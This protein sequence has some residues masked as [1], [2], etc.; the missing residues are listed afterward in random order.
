M[1][2]FSNSN[3]TFEYSQKKLNTHRESFSVSNG[4]VGWKKGEKYLFYCPSHVEGKIILRFHDN[5]CQYA[6]STWACQPNWPPGVTT[7]EEHAS[8]HH[9]YKRNVKKTHD[10]AE[11]CNC[12]APQSIQQQ[13]KNNIIFLRCM[14]G[15]GMYSMHGICT[16]C[17]VRYMY[18]MHGICTVCT[19]RYMYSMYGICTVCTTIY[20]VKCCVRNPTLPRILYSRAL[21]QCFN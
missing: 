10:V 18:S 12:R 5:P 16:V 20:I 11:V 9:N 8:T 3:V 15:I 17:T 6:L 21:L 19:V 1:E 2:E 13:Q 7:V 14:Y 4:T